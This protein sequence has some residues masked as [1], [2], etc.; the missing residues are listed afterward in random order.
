[1]TIVFSMLKNIFAFT[2]VDPESGHMAGDV[3]V[4]HSEVFMRSQAVESDCISSVCVATATT[5]PLHHTTVDTPVRDL[6][7]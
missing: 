2:S 3:G 5:V 6:S 4:L 1:M 7:L